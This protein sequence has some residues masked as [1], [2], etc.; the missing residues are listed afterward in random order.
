MKN[1]PQNVYVLRPME[2]WINLLDI[3]IN[4]KNEPWR[5]EF[6]RPRK[7]KKKSLDLSH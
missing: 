5:R 1:D 3:F 7:K 4:N 6:H 2:P